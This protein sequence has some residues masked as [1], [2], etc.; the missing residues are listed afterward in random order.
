[1][2]LNALGIVDF[3]ISNVVGGV[4]MMFSFLNQSMAAATQRFLSF[5]IGRNNTERLKK[6]FSTSVL[7]HIAIAIII[8]VLSETIGLWF[9][10][11][12]MNI[13]HDRIVATNWVFQCSVISFMVTIMNVPFYALIIAHEKIKTFAYVSLLEILLKLLIVFLLVFSD[14]DKLIFY[15]IMSLIVTI[16]IRITYFIYCKFNFNECNL[17]FIWDKRLFKNMASFSGW[18]L[19]GSGAFVAKEQGVNIV[20]NIF[21]GVAVNASR[22]IAYQVKSAVQGFV[23][24]FQTAI[25]PQITKSFASGDISYMVDLITQ[26]ARFSYY[27]LFIISLPVLIETNTILSL[28]LN[29]VPNYAVIFVRLVLI[30]SLIDSL[31][32]TFSMA[33][34][35]TGQIKN[36]QIVVGGL[37]F[38]NLPI[39]YILLKNGFPPQTTMIVA[40]ITSLLSIYFYIWFLK[41]RI[42][43][44][45]RVFFNKV[46]MNVFFV[47]ICGA[48]L[49]IFMF[50][51]LNDGIS[52][53][54][55]ISIMSIL[56]VMLSIYFIG[57]S[58][59]ERALVKIKIHEVTKKIF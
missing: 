27:I 6:V 21:C 26:G 56:S 22:G 8:F 19:I 34:L 11:T 2:V 1:L 52:R 10:N 33:M 5:E 20:I 28:W 31:T 32:G 55:I 41:R 18:D 44:N 30:S 43:F 38:T 48:I 23:S 53:M 51:Y 37:Q 14:Y 24:N 47:S 7:I 29:L 13:D 42:N 15:S 3:G 54:F 4:V 59:H 57:L 45:G 58:S 9:L 39:S 17:K 50:H 40:I 36:Y 25:N 46:L 49:P 35:A 12:K 16:V